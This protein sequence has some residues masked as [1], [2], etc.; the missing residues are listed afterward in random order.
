MILSK[1]YEDAERRLER[2]EITL[3]EF[4]RL[5]DI[6]VIEPK[7]GENLKSDYPSLFECSVCGASCDDTIPWDCDINFCPN[8]GCAMTKEQTMSRWIDA[9][10]VK[11]NINTAFWSE[12][13]KVID[14]APSI[15]PNRILPERMERG[16][17]YEVGETIVVMNHDDYY[18]LL[19]KSWE[20][21]RGEW[22]DFKNGWKCSA[23][24]K[25][26]NETSNF[27]PNCGADMREREGE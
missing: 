24:G 3:G 17:I 19:C 7:R 21:K 10:A 1:V 25:W 26:N 2:N 16:D 14:S 6:E 15:E 18:D 23:C 22:I 11:S 27:C 13:G 5:V 9:D 4:E 8:C 12:I 20:P